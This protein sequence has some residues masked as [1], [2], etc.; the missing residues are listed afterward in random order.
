MDKIRTSVPS[1]PGGWVKEVVIRKSG[2][3]AGKSD[4]Y[5][6]RYVTY[7]VR[8]S[9]TGCV[10][11]YFAITTFYKLSLLFKHSQNFLAFWEFQI[12]IVIRRETV[13]SPNSHIN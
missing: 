1:L 2:A 10:C 12:K 13:N 8:L 7:I 5:Y 3:S 9:Y 6:Y 4:V 11:I